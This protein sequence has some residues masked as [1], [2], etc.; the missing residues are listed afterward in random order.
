ML[1][2]AFAVLLALHGIA[3]LVGFLVP[4]R[5]M[6]A[7]E[8]PYSTTILAGRVDLGPAGIRIFGAAWLLGCVAFL[9]A[10]GGAATQRS[11]WTS[12]AV[13][14]ALFSLILSFLAWPEARIGVWLNLVILA[15]LFLDRPFSWL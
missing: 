14:A 6:E 9:V 10:S 15:G 8:L 5:L 1:R 2:I 12:L 13:G 3:H 11:W 7:E 4:W